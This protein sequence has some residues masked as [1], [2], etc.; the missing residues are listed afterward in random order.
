MALFEGAGVA[1]VTPMKENGDVCSLCA[2]IKDA[3]GKAL[4]YVSLQDS[5]NKFTNEDIVKIDELATKL[6]PLLGI[7]E[8]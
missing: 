1:I 5:E 6:S 8:K 4:G 7:A 3:K 2:I